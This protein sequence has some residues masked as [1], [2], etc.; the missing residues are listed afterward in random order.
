MAQTLASQNKQQSTKFL[1]TLLFESS[2]K[3]RGKS[4]GLFLYKYLIYQ[5]HCEVSFHSFVIKCRFLKG[6]NSVYIKISVYSMTKKPNFLLQMVLSNYQKVLKSA[7][8]QATTLIS[9]C[10]DLQTVIY[11]F[12]LICD[13]QLCSSAETFSG[14]CGFTIERL[15]F[16]FLVC[17]DRLE[18]QGT[19]TRT[20]RRLFGF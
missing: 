7:L 20:P 5:I 1:S 15:H 2:S 8:F 12:V 18:G 6:F 17:L 13:S 14:L 9:Y 4:V 3:I 16:C 11:Q 19:G 10:S